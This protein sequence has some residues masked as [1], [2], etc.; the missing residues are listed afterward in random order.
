MATAFLV[1]IFVIVL[2]AGLIGVS[3]L[4]GIEAPGARTR[5]FDDRQEARGPTAA[6]RPDEADRAIPPNPS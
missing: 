4:H 6:R 2:I 3:L 5:V 1:L